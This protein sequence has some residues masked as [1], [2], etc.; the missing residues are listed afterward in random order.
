MLLLLLIPLATAANYCLDE[1]TL[2]IENRKTITANGSSNEIIERQYIKCQCQN[3]Q[4]I[5]TTKTLGTIILFAISL[6]ILFP[7]IRI[8]NIL[9]GLGL[10]VSGV[11]AFNGLSFLS[12]YGVVS[13][14]GL[15]IQ[16]ISIMI[17]L[18]GFFL[19]ASNLEI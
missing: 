7:K 5:E 1:N 6:L 12:N 15:I 14:S 17:I 3:N 4:C 16:P 19:I 11:M 2:V 13:L 8:L 9:S 18:I 10:I